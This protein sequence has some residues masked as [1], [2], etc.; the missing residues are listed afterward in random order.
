VK[1]QTASA[2]HLVLQLTRMADGTRKLTAIT[3]ITGMEQDNITMQDIFVFDKQGVSPE[4]KVKGAFRATGIR[5]KCGDL[6]AA[7][8]VQLPRQMF[9]HLQVVA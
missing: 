2:I 4:G 1:Q 6:I 8:G 5:P 3:E 9:E 7:S